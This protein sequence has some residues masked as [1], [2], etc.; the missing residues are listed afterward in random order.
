MATT[1]IQVR[2]P[3][4][5]AAFV[6]RRAMERQTTRTSVI[7]EAITSLREREIEDSLREGYVELGAWLAQ[8]AEAGLTADR[9][10]LPEW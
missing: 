3:D 9:E 6:E 4:W 5:A 1:A 10:T 2:L 7:V 8:E